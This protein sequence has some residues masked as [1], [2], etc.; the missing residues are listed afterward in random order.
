MNSLERHDLRACN[1]RL[2]NGSRTFFAASFLLPRR[3]REPATALYAFCR[4]ADDA[5]DQGSAS[6]QTL[7]GL[8]HRLDAIY[9][10]CPAPNP[11][12]RAFAR[13]VKDFRIPRALPDALLEG[14]EW[15]IRR[16][17]YD[18]VDEVFDYSVR[19]AG[20][21]GAMM[22]L[23]MGVRTP[24]AIARA[25]ELGMAMQLTNIARDVGEDAR[26]GRL[27]LPR[28]WLREQGIDP[29][30]WLR[31]PCHSAGLAAVIGRLLEAA[32]Q[33]YASAAAGISQLP[34][35]CRPGIRCARL[36]Y[37]EIGRAIEHRGMNS[38]AGRA[39]VSGQR[40][41]RL[42]LSAL[43]PSFSTSIPR[44][45]VHQAA[46]FIVDS[47]VTSA[48]LGEDAGYP[49]SAAWWELS[50]RWAWAIELFAR[51]E[52]DKRAVVSR[53]GYVSRE[54]RGRPD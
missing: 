15:D 29:Q 31:N 53:G 23:I 5:I 9:S 3:V 46:R 6:D 52:R 8:R 30:D 51:V 32:D 28:R 21:V 22:A 4:V 54:P 47:V 25:C 49:Y 44:H 39:V 41:A 7:A 34:P 43:Q 13:V 19:V 35:S 1:G 18:T 37:A 26:A 14:F 10:D 20:T 45:Q 48:R 40:K 2:R 27:Y 38:V 36:V 11:E 42:V 50:K 16:R 33:L 17:T 24:S 12:D